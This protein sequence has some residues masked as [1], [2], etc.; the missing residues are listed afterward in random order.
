M[1]LVPTTVAARESRAVP[2]QTGHPMQDFGQR[3]QC[4]EPECRVVLSRY[5]PASRCTLHK[6]WTDAVPTRRRAG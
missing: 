4:E 3:R 2:L 6:G 5:N 1:S